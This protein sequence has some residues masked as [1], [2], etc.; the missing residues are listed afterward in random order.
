M[1][2]I[3][4]HIFFNATGWRF[5]LDFRLGFRHW[6]LLVRFAQDPGSFC[7]SLP[8]RCLE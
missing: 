1:F 3:L 2:V 8:E 6:F 7:N 4:A 5:H